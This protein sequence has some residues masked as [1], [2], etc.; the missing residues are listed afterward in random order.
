MKTILLTGATGTMGMAAVRE[1]IE[2][3]RNGK[4][5]L[6]VRDS[7]KNRKKMA[8]IARMPSIEIIWGD[9]MDEKKVAECVGR[10]D[11][12]LHLG[13]M[14]SP[15]A[16]YEPEKTMR[17][18]VGAMHNIINAVNKLPDPG[19]C[20]VVYIG[21]VSQYGPR[22]VPDHWADAGELMV[23]EAFGYY[24]LSKIK[25]ERELAESG[26]PR[27]VSL[28]LGSILSADLLKK[29]TDPIAMHVPLRG[30]LEWTTDGD[31]GRLLMNFFN[32]DLPDHFWKRFYNIGSGDS[33]RLTYLDFEQ[34][35]LKAIG[36]PPPEKIFETRWFA[37][38]NFHGAWFR[39]SDLL[40]SFLHFR[41]G[42]DVDTHFQ[43]MRQGLPWYFHLTPLAPAPL[44]RRIMKKSAQRWPFGTLSWIEESAPKKPD[45][46]RKRTACRRVE[47]FFG[48]REQWKRIPGWRPFLDMKIDNREMTPSIAPFAFINDENEITP[49]ILRQGAQRLGG[50]LI[51][52]P[53]FSRGEKLMESV[54]EWECGAGHR[55]RLRP[56]SLL[57]GG[58]WCPECNEI[59]C[60]S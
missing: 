16:D 37:S 24:G 33:F 60:Y 21:S 10:A 6:L 28:R 17:V 19:K 58:H 56:A 4:L 1:Y 43:R 53:D 14:V 38:D 22:T 41:E 54:L 59:E 7:A 46:E 47:A 31:C 15:A 52:E 44:I 2:N 12:V 55:F 35:L 25:A 30:V 8:A 11:I 13:G 3:P 40:D 34:R 32:Y 5:L 57:R 36:A 26:L 49:D 23:A 42:I 45:S 29:G 39:D 20:A 51:S 27:W 48:S 9:L 18:N 50:R